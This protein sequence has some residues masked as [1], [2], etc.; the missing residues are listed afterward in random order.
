LSHLTFPG[1]FLTATVGDQLRHKYTQQLERDCEGVGVSRGKDSGLV[2]LFAALFYAFFV[3]DIYGDA[4]GWNDAM[5]LAC[6]IIAVS[7]LIRSVLKCVQRRNFNKQSA[8]LTKITLE[9]ESEN[10]GVRSRTATLRSEVVSNPLRTTTN[11]NSVRLSTFV[12]E[13]VEV[14][15]DD[16][17]NL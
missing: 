6:C 16:N 15:E 3:F 9:T 13:G 7:L 8:A 17:S 12:E 11:A 2:I 5:I 4:A 1:Y 14:S 10:D